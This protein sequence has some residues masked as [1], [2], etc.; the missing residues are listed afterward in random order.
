[1]KRLFLPSPCLI[2]LQRTTAT[3]RYGGRQM[4]FNVIFF[5]SPNFSVVIFIVQIQIL[6]DT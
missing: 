4:L 6:I 5:L 2:A 1:M 3:K